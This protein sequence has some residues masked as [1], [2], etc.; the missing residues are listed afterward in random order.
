M[1]ILYYLNNN[2]I[3][4]KK[5][6]LRGN[7]ELVKF[8][9][10]AGAN[11]YSKDRYNQTVLH[12]AVQS[13]HE[14]LVKF[15]LSKTVDS[16]AEASITQ[17]PAKAYTNRAV[18]K[19]MLST[20]GSCKVGLECDPLDHSYMEASR[21]I[22]TSETH[23]AFHLRGDSKFQEDKIYNMIIRLLLF[24]FWTFFFTYLYLIHLVW[25]EYIYMCNKFSCCFMH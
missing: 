3:Q 19:D 4:Y 5:A 10:D 8:L 13:N 16:K 7:Y 6:A 25:L 20:A 1:I 12:Y 15:I 17:L 24:C 11:I 9:F 22:K 23:N 14:K 21:N 18:P 2:W